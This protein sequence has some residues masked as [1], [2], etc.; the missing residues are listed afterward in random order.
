MNLSKFARTGV[1]VSLSVLTG[2][3]ILFVQS[4]FEEADRKAAIGVVQQYRSKEGR[5]LPEVLDELHPGKPAVWSA[6]TESSCFQHVRVRA[7]VS[8]PD[9]AQPV[10]YDFVVDING[11]SIHPGNPAGEKALGELGRPKAA[12]AGSVGS[13]AGAAPSVASSAGSVAPSASAPAAGTEPR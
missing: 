12:G 7:N 4:K 9:M 10:A 6:G 1:L 13:A 5:T 2:G 8:A 3:V 11:P